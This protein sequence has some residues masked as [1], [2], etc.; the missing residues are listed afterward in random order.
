MR[1]THDEF[2]LDDDP[3]RVDRDA[4]WQYVSTEAYWARWRTREH[5][6]QQIDNAWRVVGVY[7]GEE[8]IGFAR[9]M[10]DGVAL[11]YL[12]DLY[13]L[14]RFRGRG[15]G[16][17]LVRAM[18]E[19]GPGASFRWM[20]HTDDAHELYAKFGFDKPDRTYL[21]RPHPSL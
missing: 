3:A 17:A 2:E 20:L 5:V 1:W 11:A 21:E 13:V 10:S 7:H 4:V 19:E 15:L 8:T 14:Q 16:V 18:I 12:A 9:A 6:E